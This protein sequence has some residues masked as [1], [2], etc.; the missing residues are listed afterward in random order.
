MSGDVDLSVFFSGELMLKNCRG[1]WISSIGILQVYPSSKRYPNL[2]LSTDELDDIR[3]WG[4]GGFVFTFSTSFA[5]SADGFCC[6]LAT[7]YF[8]WVGFANCLIFT[9]YEK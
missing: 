2:R 3:P 9:F 1:I 6:P 4:L 7:D 5:V 8:I